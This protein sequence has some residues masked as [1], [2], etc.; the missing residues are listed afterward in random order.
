[1][2][3]SDMGLDVE[4]SKKILIVDDEQVFLEQLKDALE[5]SSLD[6][7]I[8]TA[9]DGMEALESLEKAYHDIV[10][11]DL[12]ML[13]RSGVEIVREA[14]ERNPH[15]GVIVLTGYASL[16]RATES[17]RLGV[18]DYL[19]KPCRVHDLKRRIDEFFQRAATRRPRSVLP[20]GAPMP[21][22]FR[23]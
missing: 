10:I 5:Q 16:E 19:T 6:L 3:N 20:G 15:I 21:I 9:R 8:D 1:M 12:K 2:A 11:T 23:A 7:Q 17:L 13:G 18:W 14:R 22:T 4:N